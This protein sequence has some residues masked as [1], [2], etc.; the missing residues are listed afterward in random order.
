[1]FVLSKLLSAITQ[2]M[3]WLA[4]WWAVSLLVL[5]HW[6]RPALW[7][8]WGGLLVLG[9]TLWT[10]APARP[11]RSPSIRSRTVCCAGKLRCTSG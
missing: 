5:L 1:M 10:F 9:P 3:F 7:M 2:P 6:R 8:L 4:L 11:H